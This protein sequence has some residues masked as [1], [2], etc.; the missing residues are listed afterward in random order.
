LSRQ[1]TLGTSRQTVRAARREAYADDPIVPLKAENLAVSLDLS[2]LSLG[3]VARRV[4]GVG[5]PALGLCSKQRLHHLASRGRRC[6]KSL[7]RALAGVLGV[8]DGW[9]AGKHEPPS[10]L[11][12]LLEAEAGQP[13]S[14]PAL[15]SRPPI[16]AEM[17]LSHTARLLSNLAGREEGLSRRVVRYLVPLLDL[18]T[19][20]EWLATRSPR[21]AQTAQPDADEFTTALAKAVQV[22]VRPW[23]SAGSRVSPRGAAMLGR[24]AEMA[25]ATAVA[26]NLEPSES[27]LAWRARLALLEEVASLY[28]QV[29][30]MSL[31]RSRRK[32]APGWATQLVQPIQLLLRE[33]ASGVERADQTR[34]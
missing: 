25:V 4:R 8:P 14:V 32:A 21:P 27:A 5:G 19:W 12:L 16:R 17:E 28:T 1:R 29:A 6:R 34:W 13:V 7:R 23:Q 3:E 26:L 2:T 33:A 15:A 11:A 9:L 22:A 30:G 24:L 20:R 10:L 18:R 31:P